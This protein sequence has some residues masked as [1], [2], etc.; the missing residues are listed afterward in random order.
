MAIKPS[1]APSKLT[2][3]QG[4]Q[5]TTMATT[6]R[7]ESLGPEGLADVGLKLVSVLGSLRSVIVAHRSPGGYRGE[8]GDRDV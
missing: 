2:G 5:A 4:K 6:A 8:W 7:L 3:G 1:T